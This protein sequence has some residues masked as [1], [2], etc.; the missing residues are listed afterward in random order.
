MIACWVEDP[1]SEAYQLHLARLPDYFWLAEDGLKFQVLLFLPFLS[2]F[3]H[4]SFPTF[5]KNIYEKDNNKN[6]SHDLED[7]FE[8][9]TKTILLQ[10]FGSQMWDAAFAIQAILA[11][12]LNEEY[13]PTLRRAHEFVKASQVINLDY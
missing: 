10:S 11:C 1:N 9:K 12:N 13:G 7:F 2:S 5:Y 4:F 6:N 8:E 3:L